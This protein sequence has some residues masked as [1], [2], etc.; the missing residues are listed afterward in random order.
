MEGV[1]ETM[2]ERKWVKKQ[3]V[4]TH[5]G[6]RITATRGVPVDTTRLIKRRQEGGLNMMNAR[7]GPIKDAIGTLDRRG[8]HEVQESEPQS[9][10]RPTSDDGM[11]LDKTDVVMRGVCPGRNESQRGEEGSIKKDVFMQDVNS[12]RCDRD[13]H[14]SSVGSGEKRVHIQAVERRVTNKLAGIGAGDKWHQEKKATSDKQRGDHKSH[15]ITPGTDQDGSRA[16]RVN[17]TNKQQGRPLSAYKRKLS[18]AVCTED[19]EKLQTNGDNCVTTCEGKAK[20][21]RKKL[22]NDHQGDVCSL[23]QLLAVL[24][25]SSRIIAWLYDAVSSWYRLFARDRPFHSRAVLLAACDVHQGFAAQ[26][27]GGTDS[28]QGKGV[29]ERANAVSWLLECRAKWNTIFHDKREFAARGI[30]EAAFG[31]VPHTL[32]AIMDATIVDDY[33][34]VMKASEQISIELSNEIEQLG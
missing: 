34:W 22:T 7:N 18:E 3:G 13:N 9:R 8:A 6:K 25:S 30:F 14:G 12:R 29:I 32:L 21:R 4:G 1:H 20:K 31:C 24:N 26:Y 15:R 28:K 2:E 16:Q 23:S 33:E 19:H 27:I 5:V 10:G 11:L 17:E